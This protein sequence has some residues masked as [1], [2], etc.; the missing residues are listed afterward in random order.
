MSRHRAAA[1]HPEPGPGILV[2]KRSGASYRICRATF[3]Y[4]TSR[5]PGAGLPS[6][7]LNQ[8]LHAQTLHVTRRLPGDRLPV[9]SHVRLRSFLFPNP[10]LSGVTGFPVRQ[11][12]SLL[13]ILGAVL[14][15][16]QAAPFMIL[17][18]PH[19]THVHTPL[20]LPLAAVARLLRAKV[21][22]TIHGTDILAVQRSR[23]LQMAIRHLADKIFYVSTA[24]REP[25]LRV[26]SENRLCYTPSGVDLS[27][28]HNQGLARK[29]QIISVGNL[30]WQKGY[31]IL[32]R[33]FQQISAKLPAY[34]LIIVGEG[35]ERG[36]L[37]GLTSELG[38]LAL[39]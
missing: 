26:F 4:P 39:N 27:L 25:L 21:V 23:L 1:C 10:V 31:P 32:L 30:R 38:I 22:I 6:Y 5:Y 8:Y 24:M 3:T 11:W 37:E 34:S 16:V 36:R 29:R 7:Y 35:Q 14:F 17:F 19:I 13:K 2:S 15:T 9:S 18:R 20:P 33:A 12:R 28:F